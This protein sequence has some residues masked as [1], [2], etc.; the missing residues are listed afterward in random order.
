[1]EIHL[2]DDGFPDCERATAAGS[3][4]RQYGTYLGLNAAIIIAGG[5]M[6]DSAVAGAG[7]RAIPN[8][9]CACPGN[10]GGNRTGE[11]R[12]P[13]LSDAGEL[14]QPGVQYAVCQL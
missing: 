6:L 2:L 12:R 11:G 4:G 5:G 3:S 8:G 1:M 7:V 14:G 9:F 13:D 10:A